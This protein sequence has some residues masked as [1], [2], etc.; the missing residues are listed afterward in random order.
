MNP[1]PNMKRPN[2]PFPLFPSIVTAIIAVSVIAGLIT[3]GSPT[4]ERLR[5][6]DDQRISRL[7]QLRFGAIDSFYADRGTLPQTLNEAQEFW[8]GDGT[9]FVD[10]STQTPFEYR[11]TGPDTYELCATFDRPMD[12]E[13][14]RIQ[15]TWEHGAGR[16]CFNFTARTTGSKAIP[17]ETVVYPK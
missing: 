15:P 1:L 11:A 3:A 2:F 4:E 6:F 13:Q 9:T 10:P 5:R 12:A 7:E 17:A 14:V 16:T 8:A